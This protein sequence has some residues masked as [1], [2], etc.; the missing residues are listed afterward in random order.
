MW[1]KLVGKLTSSYRQ[2]VKAKAAETTQ[3]AAPMQRES[4]SGDDLP[5][6]W[7]PPRVETV[8][9]RKEP[10]CEHSFQPVSGDERCVHCGW[11]KS[12]AKPA[13]FASDAPVV[14]AGF[15]AD[16]GV[17]LK[18]VN[19]TTHTITAEGPGSGMSQVTRSLL[20]RWNRR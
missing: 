18:E 4:V 16:G 19:L 13:R 2:G 20:N 12:F 7:R 1:T 9:P 14:R 10:A 17:V 3:P 8:E 15:G 5:I 11:Q 6:D